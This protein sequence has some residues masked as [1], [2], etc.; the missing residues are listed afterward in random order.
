MT[1]LLKAM[2]VLLMI[3]LNTL[4]QYSASTQPMHLLDMMQ[5]MRKYDD[6]TYAHSMNLALICNIIG[7]C[8]NLVMM[9]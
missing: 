8:L 7:K 1:L 4:T 6:L 5:C 9:I 3:C 2:M